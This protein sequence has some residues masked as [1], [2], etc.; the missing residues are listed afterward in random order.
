MPLGGM[1]LDTLPPLLA[2]LRIH[3][4]QNPLLDLIERECALRGVKMTFV[5]N[6][7]PVEFC[8]NQTHTYVK[9][10]PVR[11]PT[12]EHVEAGKVRHISASEPN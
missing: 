12:R 4:H 2:F 1:L 10:N 3:L 5:S 11:N 6:T 7:S 9:C 8:K